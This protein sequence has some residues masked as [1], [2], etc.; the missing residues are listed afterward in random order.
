M[1]HFDETTPGASFLIITGAEALAAAAQDDIDPTLYDEPS[2]GESWLAGPIA[3]RRGSY[4]PVLSDDCVPWPPASLEPPAPFLLPADVIL[5]DR[6]R[7]FH[8]Q[9]RKTYPPVVG[10]VLRISRLT[11]FG[12]PTADHAL[13]F[14]FYFILGP[15][16][17]FS[18]TL[19]SDRSLF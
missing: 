6:A 18:L 1:R 2:N 4:L 12:A 10:R 19:C 13:P 17:V 16:R 9:Q 3:A 8:T 11:H 14:Q 5:A 15:L 7:Q